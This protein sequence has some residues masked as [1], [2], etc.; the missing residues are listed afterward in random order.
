RDGGDYFNLAR[1]N[2]DEAMTIA[3]R[4]EM[5]LHE[6]DCHLEY[7]R[8]HLAQGEKAQAHDHFKTARAMIHEMGYHRRDKDL[9]EIEA[10][11]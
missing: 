2:V 11:L 1:R 6:C 3:K 8:L 7:A 4:G 5:R 10:Q 9:A